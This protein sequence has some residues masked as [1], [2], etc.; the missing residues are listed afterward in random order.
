LGPEFLPLLLPLLKDREV[1]VAEAVE[2]A[3]ATAATH[4]HLVL[5]DSL[6][7]DPYAGT[8][9]R[10]HRIFEAVKRRLNLPKDDSLVSGAAMR[11]Y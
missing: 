5:L 2:N 11:A 9:N 8:R 4:E 3:W 10:A 6:L 7:S 1:Q